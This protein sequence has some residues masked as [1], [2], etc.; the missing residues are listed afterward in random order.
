MGHSTL[1]FKR[2]AFAERKL[3]AGAVF[4]LLLSMILTGYS[5]RRPKVSQI[6]S[7]VVV[8][9]LSPLQG[10]SSGLRGFFA[11]VYTHYIALGNVARENAI[12]RE[13]LSLLRNSSIQLSEL[14]QE[15]DHLR[16]LLSMPTLQE[17]D[18]I[19]ADV[20]AFDPS[21]WVEAVTI[22]VGESSGVKPGMAVLDNNGIVGQVVSTSRTSASVLLISDQT[23]GVDAYLQESRVRG[24]VEGGGHFRAHW[25]YVLAESEVQVG[26]QVVASG[27]DGIYPKGALIGTVIEVERSAPGRLFREIEIRPSVNFLKLERVV[28]MRKSDQ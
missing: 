1:H 2:S 23:S 17:G 7:A 9:L 12:L 6:G 16:E 14:Q 13:Q 3:I 22:N 28:V 15:N 19:A 11:N 20:V 18:L 27:L 26:D 8:E 24:I 5:A 4:L 10:L 21:L 25:N